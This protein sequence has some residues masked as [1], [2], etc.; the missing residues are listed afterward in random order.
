MKVGPVYWDVPGN[1][2]GP[3]VFRKGLVGRIVVEPGLKR[4]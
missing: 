4:P 2:T 3:G 1:I